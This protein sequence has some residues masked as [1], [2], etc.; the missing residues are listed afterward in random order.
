MEILADIKFI[1]EH[2]DW[3]LAVVS[4]C[5]DTEHEK[6]QNDDFLSGH[7]Y[8]LQNTFT[9]HF[10]VYLGLVNFNNKN[11]Y[12][13][14]TDESGDDVMTM[15]YIGRMIA[16]KSLLRCPMCQEVT[17]IESPVKLDDGITELVFHCISCDFEF[18]PLGEM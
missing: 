8:I 5:C 1:D 3:K 12:V 18:I 10:D 14:F 15:S 6:I 17:A 7:W 13:S 2:K 16:P 9:N 4:F 11:A